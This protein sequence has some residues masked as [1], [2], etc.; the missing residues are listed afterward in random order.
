MG[1]VVATD[2]ASSPE[3]KHGERRNWDRPGMEDP[4]WLGEVLGLNILGDVSSSYFRMYY[5]AIKKK[6]TAIRVLDRE[7]SLH[8]FPSF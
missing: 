4:V 2:K 3:Q 5:K 6:K 7:K 8:T 1:S